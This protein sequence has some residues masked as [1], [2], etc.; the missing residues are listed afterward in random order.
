M[1]IFSPDMDDFLFEER[2]MRN[3]PLPLDFRHPRQVFLGFLD[4]VYRA[5]ESGLV[6]EEELTELSLLDLTV[7]CED[8]SQGGVEVIVAIELRPTVNEADVWR[9]HRCAAALRSSGYNAVA[10]VDGVAI[11]SEAAKLA[12]ELGVRYWLQQRTA[13]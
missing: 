13:A 4:P 11:V 6:S 3:L 9:A 5:V 10:L 2:Y 1:A 12:D 8:R 7:M